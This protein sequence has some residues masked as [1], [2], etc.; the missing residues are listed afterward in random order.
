MN[1]ILEKEDGHLK[2]RAMLSW[3]QLLV[4]CCL[5]FTF[6]GLTAVLFEYQRDEKRF[7]QIS[8]QLFAEEIAGNTLNM[9][10][11]LAYPADFGIYSYKATLPTYSAE[12]RL[13]SRTATEN[14]LNSLEELNIQK[15]N[16]SDQYACILL[17]RSLENNLTLN[18]FTYYEE[19]LSPSSGMQSQLPI[20][21]AEYTFRTKRDVEDYLALLDQTDD[22]LLS[23]LTFEQEKAEAGL[24]MS[25]ASLDKVKQQCDSILTEEELDAGTHFLQTTFVER[26][27]PLLDQKIISEE[28]ALH[29]QSQNNR[30]LRTVI[31]P[32][33][34]T[35]AD[36]LFILEDETIPLSGLASKPDGREYYRTLL[37]SETGSYRDIT[38]IKRLLLDQFSE[39]Y[40]T[41]RAL[42]AAHPEIIGQLSDDTLISFPIAGADAMLADLQARMSTDFPSLPVE[43]NNAGP[44][45]SNLPTVTVKAVSPSLE[46]YCA[47]AFY[48][49]TPIDDTDNNVIYINN[50]NSPSGLELYTTLAHE[51]YPGHLYQTVYHNR[52][53][54]QNDENN[55]RELLWYGGYLEG[56]ALY[57]EFYSF[58]YAADAYTE[59][60]AP[61]AAILTQLE[62]HNR[63]LQLCLYCLLDIM[64]HYDNASY[65]QVTEVLQ[66][67]GIDNSSSIRSVYTYLVEEPCNYLKYYL[68]YLEILQLKEQAKELWG[69][70]YSDLRF[71]TF[72]LDCGPSDF[73]TLKER[74]EAEAAGS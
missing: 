44:A 56:W 61:A 31:L 71:H 49:T 67:V 63:S 60:G 47:P 36:G 58:D 66:G 43:S 12:G 5:L 19:P 46:A 26:L 2:Q 16:P 32:A 25:A 51:G 30:L 62:Q 69:G 37:I 64:I 72:Y 65:S 24:L 27:Q 10:Y 33:Y 17:M 3:K 48:L 34:E 28:E 70:E 74:L 68:G 57:A 35:L 23:L 9:H 6:A 29:Y 39:E 38:E 21:L 55:V 13:A 45:A 8:S 40:N 4:L 14:L 7:T 15:L 42:A 54:L 22:Y 53:F 59:Q 11:T 73:T 50:K 18:S 41:I 52:N 1:D 20:L